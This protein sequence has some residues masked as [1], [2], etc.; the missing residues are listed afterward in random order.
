MNQNKA[1]PFFRILYG[2]L[3][4]FLWYWVYFI[5]S[6]FTSIADGDWFLLIVSFAICIL[7][8]WI[9]L[10]S[11]LVAI[12]GRLPIKVKTHGQK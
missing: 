2:C 3:A 1:R 11:S 9:G 7:F 12:N 5:G 6:T 4:C 8:S 10:L